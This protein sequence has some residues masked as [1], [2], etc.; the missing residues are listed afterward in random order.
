MLEMAMND[1]SSNNNTEELSP[2]DG[3]Y[4]VSSPHAY[5]RRP[6]LG[7]RVAAPASIIPPPDYGVDST[8]PQS[9][10]RFVTQFLVAYL[11]LSYNRNARP[12]ANPRVPKNG[13][14]ML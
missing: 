12:T 11:P 2:D 9:Q 13:K 1:E 8:V 10:A 3:I 6:S 14:S 7:Q 4:T 5:D